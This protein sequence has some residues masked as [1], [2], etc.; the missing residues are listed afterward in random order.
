MTYFHLVAA[1]TSIKELFCVNDDYSLMLFNTKEEAESLISENR[2]LVEVL[3]SADAIEV[4]KDSI[5][6]QSVEIENDGD[7]F[8]INAKD[9]KTGMRIDLEGDEFADPKGDN[10]I[11]QDEYAEVGAVD[12]ETE[13]C[14]CIYAHNITVG[15]PV[16]HKIKLNAHIR[17]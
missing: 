3:A 12:I 6:V 15:F 9:L 14:V 11:L 13:D 4:Q 10:T 2:T 7:T 1:D 16:E 17:N 5:A 8:I